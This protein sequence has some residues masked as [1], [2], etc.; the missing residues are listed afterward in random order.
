[1]L[2]LQ[3]ELAV[4]SCKYGQYRPPVD[5]NDPIRASLI[6]EFED[7]K[8]AMDLSIRRAYRFIHRIIQPDKGHAASHPMGMTQ[9]GSPIG[10][11]LGGKP[12]ADHHL[13]SVRLNSNLHSQPFLVFHQDSLDSALRKTSSL[14][15]DNH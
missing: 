7:C 9:S 14:S 10:I 15:T 5:A 1:M 4:D 2:K 8:D 12:G 11:Q 6:G 3:E 13:L